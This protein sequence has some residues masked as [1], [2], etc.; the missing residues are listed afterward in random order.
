MAQVLIIIG[1]GESQALSIL[2][3]KTNRKT[4][5]KKT[6]LCKI[7]ILQVGK[8]GGVCGHFF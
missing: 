5:K 4:H 7:W 3:V 1:E 8:R 6:K 2:N